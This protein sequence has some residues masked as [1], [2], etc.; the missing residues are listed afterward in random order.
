MGIR[1]RLLTEADVKAVLTMDDLI[2][3]MA[4]ALQR[5]S[6]GRVVAAGAPDDPDR[7][8]RVLCHD[9]RLRSRRRQQ[10]RDDCPAAAPRRS[11]RSWSPS[12][13]A[14]PRGA[15]TRTSRSIVL[16]DPETGALL[17]LLDGRYITEARTAAVSAVSSRLLA[18]EDGLVARD[19]RIRRPGAQPPR[20][21]VA[22]APAAPGH[23]LESEQTAPRPVRR[24]GKNCDGVT[25]PV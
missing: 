24:R 22:G 9:A 19:H 12:S 10:G 25:T 5:F 16:L 4:S 23:G 8:R 20:R 17:A 11:A 18:R 7:G 2:E 13:A 21:A 15:C 6:T 1:F 14:T 3:T